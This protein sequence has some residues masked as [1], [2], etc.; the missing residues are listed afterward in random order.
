MSIFD[1]FK[2][3]NSTLKGSDWWDSIVSAKSVSGVTVNTENAMEIGAVYAC[4][5]I[6]SETI[7]SLPIHVYQAVN[8]ERRMAS[9]H[10]LNAVLGSVSN[11]D[12]TAM[13][14][15]ELVMSSLC[16][17]GNAYC[18]VQRDIRRQV[19]SLWP[20]QPEHMNIMRNED[21]TLSYVWAYKNVSRMF[22]QDQIWRVC[23]LGK[24]GIVGLSPVSLAKEAMGISVSAEKSAARLFSNG[25]QTSMA[26]EFDDQL[27]DEQVE[28]LRKQWSENYSGSANAHKPIILESGMKAKSIGMTADDAQ[29]LESRKWQ[30]AEIARW[31]RVPLHM[32][33]ELDRAT[34]S[35]IEHQS[36]EF[37]QHTIRPWLVRLE[38]TISRDLLTPREREQGYFVSHSVEGLLRGDTASRYEAYGKAIQDG[39][40]NR[41]EVRRLENLNPAEGLDEYL[42]PLNMQ[43]A[44]AEPAQDNSAPSNRIADLANAENRTLAK[45]LTRSPTSE[46][47]A[48]WAVDYYRRQE[49]K[50]SE[51]LGCDANGYAQKRLARMADAREPIDAVTAATKHTEADIEGLIHE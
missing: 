16:L 19:V 10:P 35:N 43:N 28:V 22:T 31:F 11:S 1:W 15:R 2:P 3:K 13:E 4:V 42:T 23:G 37:V 38:Q 41:N 27:T 26:L 29:F 25:Q 48:A 47:F 14:L 46:E 44:N 21:G 7:S 40:M 51:S 18:Y 12:M 5:R 50:L 17:H 30:I 39:W 36:I 34:F 20:L 32:L 33:N 9:D 49:A 6:L 24:D 45:E 8:G